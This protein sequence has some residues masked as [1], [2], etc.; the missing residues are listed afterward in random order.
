MKKQTF[1]IQTWKSENLQLVV[2]SFLF[3]LKALNG[4]VLHACF[5]N[6]SLTFCHE[7]KFQSS[8]HL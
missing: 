2:T 1:I 7:I 8:Q 3:L 6:K 5:S 4:N